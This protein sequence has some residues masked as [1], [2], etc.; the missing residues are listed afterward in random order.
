VE[1]L[2]DRRSYPDSISPDGSLLA[3]QTGSVKTGSDIW[4]MPLGA[5]HTPRPLL[6]TPANEAWAEISPDGRWMAFGSDSSGRYEVYVQPFPGP[7]PRQQIS[8]EGGTSPL[9]ATSGRE[10]FFAGERDKDGAVRVLAIDVSAGATF[11]AGKP[12]ELFVGRY[13]MTGGPTGYDVSRDGKR[14]LMA[15]GLEPSKQPATHLRVVL[16]WFEELRRAQGI[17]Q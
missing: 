6:Q 2:R 13:F 8:F 16:N 12:R 10:L 5:D 4:L 7:G 1:R 3:F 9:W 15:E 14:F 11:S 17:D